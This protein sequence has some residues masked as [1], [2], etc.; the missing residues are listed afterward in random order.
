M[1][2]R[3][4]ST[5]ELPAALMPL[6]YG[7]EPFLACAVDAEWNLLAS[8]YMLER[9]AGPIAPELFVPP[10]NLLRLVLHPRGVSS[11]LDNLAEVHGHLL[12]RLRRRTAT[13]GTDF[14]FRLEREV[15][16][17]RPAP[18]FDPPA[19][20]GQPI[21]MSVRLWVGSTLTNLISAPVFFGTPWESSPTAVTAE[22]LFPAD[23][24]TREF[25]FTGP[26]L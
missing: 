20:D 14:L 22:C 10:V 6:L 9:L 3:Q 17:Y 15:T 4:R 24:Q 7:H 5:A 1:S 19:A 2:H 23:E 21:S 13:V 8:N 18:R 16:G 11:R 12:R 25:L 26:V